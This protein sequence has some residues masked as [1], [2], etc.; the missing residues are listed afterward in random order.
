MKGKRSL[1]ILAVS[2]MVLLGIQSY[3]FAAFDSG[4]TGEDGAFEPTANT[5]LQIPESGVFNFTTVNIPSGV[6]VTFSKNSTNTPVTI[7]ASGDVAIAGTIS[8]NGTNGS[9]VYAGV[10]G[11]GGYGGGSGGTAYQNGRRGEGPGSGGGGTARSDRNN[12]SGGGG[13]GG[14]GYGGS[15]G[16]TYD[17]PYPGGSGGPSYSNDRILP[18]IG[19][20]GGGGGGGTT[21]YAGG[22]GGGGGGSIIIASSGTITVSGSITANGGNGATGENNGYGGGGGGGSGGS[23]RL[24]CNTLAG[25]GAITAAAGAGGPS[26]WTAGGAGGS[27]RVRL[28]YATTT[29]TASVNPP[30]S[31][32][33][34]TAVVPNNLPTL[35]ITSIGGID[36]PASP[37]GSFS[38]P[39]VMLP[40]N[41]TNPV[42]V[43]VTASNIPVGTVV[44]V[45]TNPAQGS[46]SSV[47]GTLTGADSSSTTATVQSSISLAYPSTLSA[48][49]TFQL[50]AI[51]GGPIYAE[52]ERVDKIRVETT[53]GRGSSVIYITESGR[54]I[55][56]KRH[57]S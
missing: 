2:L 41:T 44:T 13:G 19:G 36:V 30:M 16:T 14:F 53:M 37:M 12:L 51:Q 56:L 15:A 31:I 9:N 47:T 3:V 29:R 55:P 11:P 43:I 57:G 42:T 24:I 54:E 39:D 21:T 18:T 35:A 7:L 49:V 17:S 38:S 25:N 8:V 52:G 26:S 48:S 46:V 40:Y 6:T 4:S 45:K 22:A 28:E 34:P 23:I 5:V 27:G 1:I 10:G 33:Y 50:A 20:S 32:G